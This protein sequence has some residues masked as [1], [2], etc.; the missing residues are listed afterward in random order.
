MG[1]LL[2][3]MIGMRMLSTV[4]DPVPHGE[5]GFVT[6]KKQGL[7]KVL[8]ILLWVYYL[9]SG[10]WIWQFLLACHRIVVFRIIYSWYSK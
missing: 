2:I 3:W 8:L 7:F 9:F 10:I 6:Y 5:T 1:V 4:G